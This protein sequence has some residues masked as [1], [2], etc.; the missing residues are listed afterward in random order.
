MT[1]TAVVP[2]SPEYVE[3]TCDICDEVISG[4]SKGAGSAKFKLASHRYRIHGIKKD[5]TVR[6]AKGKVEEGTARPVMGVVRAVRDDLAAGHGAPSEEQL[7]KAMGRTLGLLSTAVASYAAETDEGLTDDERDNVISYLSLSQ[8]AAK[9]VVR[10]LAHLAAPSKLNK[11]FGRVAVDNVD[12][13]GSV[14]ELGELLFHWRR[15]F[16]DRAARNPQP[17]DVPARLVPPGPVMN[18]DAPHNP[19]G[20]A[21]PAEQVVTSGAPMQGV[22]V[23]AEMLEASRANRRG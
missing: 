10:P 15:Y 2:T 19:G 1:D 9:D 23:S 20:T 14:L 11:K 17:L 5:G 3:L 18:G 22:V 7:S 21:T 13:V 12:A 8:T 4:P 6:P 16:R